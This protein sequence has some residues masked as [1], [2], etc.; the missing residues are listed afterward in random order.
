MTA[1]LHVIGVSDLRSTIET[2]RER[3]KERQKERKRESNGT[4]REERE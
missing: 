4:E 3:D 1:R 2:E